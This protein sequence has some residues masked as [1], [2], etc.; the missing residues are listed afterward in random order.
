M[1]QN[2]RVAS[3][4]IRA[5]RNI[6]PRTFC[7]YRSITAAIERGRGDPLDR[8]P[9]R[10]NQR[11]RFTPRVPSRDVAEG[12]E[13]RFRRGYRNRDGHV[14]TRRRWDDDGDSFQGPR[15]VRGNDHGNRTSSLNRESLPYTTAASEFLYGYSSVLAALK[16]NRRRLYK[17]YVLPRGMNNERSAALLTR[18]KRLKV[19]IQEVGDEYLP[20]FSK[21]SSGR[22]HNVSASVLSISNPVLTSRVGLH[23]GDIPPSCSQHLRL[24]SMLG[25]EQRIPGQ[26]GATEQRGTSSQRHAKNISVPFGR[27]EI[28]TGD[29]CRRGAR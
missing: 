8:R 15:D 22:P 20:A 13:D 6:L 24:G 25:H 1:L 12:G 4:S 28:S 17:L 2:G 23:N 11:D 5:S 3:S 19:T 16:A 10:S 29:L 14:D 18:A 21:A 7:R 27:M 9:A 26:P